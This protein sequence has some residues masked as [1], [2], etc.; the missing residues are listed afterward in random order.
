M[1]DEFF[2]FFAGGMDTTS[3]LMAMCLYYLAKFPLIQEN[4]RK[5]INEIKNL[6][7]TTLSKLPYLDSV[8]NETNRH[9]GFMLSIFPRE[10]LRDHQLGH[11]AV[12]KG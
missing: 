2:T 11:I 6:D 7:L 10:A 3:H 1:V 12:K 5:E 9:Y 4:L 8:I